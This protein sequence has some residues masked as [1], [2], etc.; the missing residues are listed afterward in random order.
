MI[1]EQ[2]PS[3]LIGRPS[4]GRGRRIDHDGNLFAVEYQP[5]WNDVPEIL[6]NYVHG[7][8]IEIPSL[9]GLA[10]RGADVAFVAASGP[11]A[12]SGLYLDAHETAVDL[13]HRVVTSRVTHRLG[14]PEVAFGGSS[15]KLQLRPLS[16]ALTILDFGLGCDL[17]FH[18][19]NKKRGLE[20][21]RPFL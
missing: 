9:V 21:P 11:D 19:A 14:N 7:K 10:S 18:R 16:T 6:R 8:E 4:T 20:R 12:G 13:D 15:N 3:L 5:C 2:V 1:A 17:K